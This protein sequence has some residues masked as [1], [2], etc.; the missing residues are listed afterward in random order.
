MSHTEKKFHHREMDINELTGLIIQLCIKIHKK[1]GPGLLEAVYEEVLCY[2]L[3]KLGI[4]FKRQ[5]GVKVIYE[6]VAMDLG[7]RADLIVDNRVIVELKSIET[8]PLVHY[9]TLQTYLKI[10][11][12]TVGLLINFNVNLLKD[13]ISRVVNNFIENE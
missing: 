10:T 3:T 12:I 4:P 8:V 6:D 5:Q 7:F 9:K 1:L 11:N 13:G 2:E